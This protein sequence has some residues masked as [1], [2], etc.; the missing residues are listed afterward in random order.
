MNQPKKIL[1]EEGDRFILIYDNVPIVDEQ[2]AKTIIK[3][4]RS[5]FQNHL[6]FTS[7]ALKS[8]ACSGAADVADIESA[9]LFIQMAALAKGYR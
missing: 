1:L 7:C 8:L 6:R 5:N 4:A 2:M 3:L 9:T